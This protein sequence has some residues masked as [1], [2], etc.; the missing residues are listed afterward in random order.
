MTGAAFL[1]WKTRTPSWGAQPWDTPRS[2]PNAALSADALELSA[3]VRTP[4]WPARSASI[5]GSD[6]RHAAVVAQKAGTN[7]AAPRGARRTGR[8]PALIAADHL[9]SWQDRTSGKI[10]ALICV[11]TREIRQVPHRKEI[12][13]TRRN[14]EGVHWI[15]RPS[16]LPRCQR[17]LVDRATASRSRASQFSS[18][19]RL[20]HRPRGS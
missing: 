3:V 19:S 9:P 6:L 18:A 12:I 17:K 15:L 2:N 16:R 11:N 7:V 13:R 8:E 4:G 14:A 5:G 20:A 10:A 1:D